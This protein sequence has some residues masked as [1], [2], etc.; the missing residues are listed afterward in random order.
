VGGGS[1]DGL[2]YVDYDERLT[3]GMSFRPSTGGAK[4]W[5]PTT[6]AGLSPAEI[7]V[8]AAITRFKG[9][10]AQF[11]MASWVRLSCQ[12]GFIASKASLIFVNGN[13]SWN[14]APDATG[15]PA[16]ALTPASRDRVVREVNDPVRAFLMEVKPRTVLAS[17]ND[18]PEFVDTPRDYDY[19]GTQELRINY[20]FTPEN[21]TLIVKNT[22][23]VKAR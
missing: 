10:Q 16:G 1:L 17:A 3:P 11:R 2:L 19:G 21:V 7:F 5:V 6:Y 22:I 18:K 9:T 20:E 15:A 12:V 14:E 4:F 23:R 13:L 8:D